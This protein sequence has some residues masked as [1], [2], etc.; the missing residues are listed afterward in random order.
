MSDVGAVGQGQALQPGG[1]D[2]AEQGK[3]FSEAAK[4][5][6]SEAAMGVEMMGS[7]MMSMAQQM[8][9]NSKGDTDE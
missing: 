8:M 9:N 2:M 5:A 1:P 4:A 7:L 6:Q 3:K